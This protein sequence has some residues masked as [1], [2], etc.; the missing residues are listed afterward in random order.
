M[1]L[2]DVRIK[3]TSGAAC[4]EGITLDTVYHIIQKDGKLYFSNINKEVEIKKDALINIF[5]PT[6]CEWKD[7]EFYESKQFKK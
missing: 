2:E 6:N 7:V 5:T 1:K 3:W 4:P